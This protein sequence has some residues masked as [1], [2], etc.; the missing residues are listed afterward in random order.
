MTAFPRPLASR[1]PRRARALRLSL[2]AAFAFAPSLAAA[3]TPS[4]TPPPAAAT[5]APASP[6]PA[7]DSPEAKAARV[8]ELRRL[9]DEAVTA[10]RYADAIGHYE[11]ALQLSPEP[12]LLYNIARAYEG[13][14]RYAD[15][16]ATLN[17]F[18]A[19]APPDLIK[20]VPNLDKRIESLR[21]RVT[22][23]TVNVNVSGARVILRNQVVGSKP[24]EGPLAISV[25]SGKATV[26]IIAEG[27]APYRKVVDLPGGGSVVLDVQLAVRDEARSSLVVTPEGQQARAVNA[28]TASSPPVWSRWWFWAGTAAVVAGGAVLIYAVTTEKSANHGDIGSGQ[29]GA[30]LVRF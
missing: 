14:G 13:V 29:V 27:Y 23:I 8:D 15:A 18:K 2:V 1:S 25:E 10:R 16:L 28:D 19:E 7:A 5:V 9:G 12:R 20:Q 4:E 21:V 30:P 26:E 17:R 6:P 24:R 22:H 11:Q 3:Q